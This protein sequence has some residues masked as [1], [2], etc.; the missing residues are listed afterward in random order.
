MQI[1]SHHSSAQNHPTV[2][3]PTQ[4]KID[5]SIESTVTCSNL[6]EPHRHYVERKK[7]D[8]KASCVIPFVKHS[9]TGKPNL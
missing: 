9:R 3:H 7:A 2:C 4:T 8:T 5:Y 1:S 6:D